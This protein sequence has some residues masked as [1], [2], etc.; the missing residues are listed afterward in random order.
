[1]ITSKPFTA[2]RVL[3][4]AALALAGAVSAPTAA[5]AA[6]GKCGVNRFCFFSEYNGE[7][8]TSSVGNVT[9]GGEC[10]SGLVTWN[11][12]SVGHP[13]SVHNTLPFALNA[14]N[15]YDCSGP[16]EATARAGATTNLHP[17]AWSFRH[18]GCPNGQ[19][20]FFT[21]RD[22]SG[23]SSVKEADNYCDDR[24]IDRHDAYSVINNTSRPIRVYNSVWC[25]GAY[26]LGDIPAGGAVSLTGDAGMTGWKSI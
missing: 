3:A 7:G 23:V 5:Q 21:E 1:M 20:C 11:D 13:L 9:M 15:S 24:P 16:V 8:L 10:V 14:Y 19:V 4:A 25:T 17:G 26:A 12:E 2:A 18:P 22:Y 6:A